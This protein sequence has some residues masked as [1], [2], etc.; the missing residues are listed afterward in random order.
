M[1]LSPGC[2]YCKLSYPFYEDLVKL[3]DQGQH[4]LQ[5]IAAVDT[6]GSVRLQKRL[7]EEA[8]IY[9]DSVVALSFLELK[10]YYVPTLV[11][12]DSQAVVQH[13]WEG[14][15]SEEFEDGVQSILFQGPNN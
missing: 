9:V 1:A 10:I 11:L 6:S 8:S 4:K 15:L 13:V 2:P 12:L 14:Q 5:I 3:R 7:L